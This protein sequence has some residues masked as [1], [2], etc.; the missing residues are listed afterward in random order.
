MGAGVCARS[1]SDRSII[2]LFLSEL[3]MSGEHTHFPPI[4]K[5]KPRLFKPYCAYELLGDLVKMQI[6]LEWVW[7]RAQGSA[8]LESSPVVLRILVLLI[9]KQQE[10]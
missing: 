2:Y 1:P 7:V 9:S 6:L 10:P 4:S 3:V 5:P 8:F